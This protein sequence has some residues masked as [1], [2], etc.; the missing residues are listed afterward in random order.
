MISFFNSNSITYNVDKKCSISGGIDH[1]ESNVIS[2]TIHTDTHNTIVDR[3]IQLD[4]KL[5]L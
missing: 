4:I 2:A 1:K 3:C 5:T